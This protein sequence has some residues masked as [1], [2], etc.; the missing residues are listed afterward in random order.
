MVNC[1]ENDII[2]YRIY[3]VFVFL[4]WILHFL[5]QVVVLFEVIEVY[6][7]NNIFNVYSHKLSDDELNN[8][9]SKMLFDKSAL[10]YIFTANEFTNDSSYIEMARRFIP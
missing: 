7:G 1:L 3:A 2:L 5:K 6:H 10:N 9:V 4:R 8:L